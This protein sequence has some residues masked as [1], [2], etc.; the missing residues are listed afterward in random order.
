MVDVETSG[1]S[2]HSHRVVEVAVVTTDAWGR[3]QHQWSSRVNPCG[4][5]GATH[6]H[7]ITQKE[8]DRAPLFGEVLPHLH[9]QLGGRVVVAHN[10]PFD[11]GFLMAEY[12]RA[13][14]RLPDVQRLCTLEASSY[15]L[16]DLPRRRLVDCCTAVGVPLER[17][18]SALPD[19]L[20]TAHL[21]RLYLDPTRGPAPLPEHLA[22]PHVAAQAGWPALEQLPRL[23][24]TP[25]HHRAGARAG[26]RSDARAAA[27]G[28][29]GEATSRR[30]GPVAADASRAA[31]MRTAVPDRPAE[32]GLLSQIK[33]LDMRDALE[34]GAPDGS[35]AYLELLAQ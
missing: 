20:G 23:D 4:P 30:G 11:L 7:G 25:A 34:E 6:V 14:V 1:F 19:A 18:H 13:F 3:V 15:Y 27:P 17:A 33:I 21:L 8:A 12:E 26:G 35:V 24:A 28:R 5:V 22:L 9:A 10:L 2:R 16:P 31:V 29:A 32:N